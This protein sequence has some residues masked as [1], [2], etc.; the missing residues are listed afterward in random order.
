MTATRQCPCPAPE[1]APSGGCAGPESCGCGARERPFA[2]RQGTAGIALHDGR[3]LCFCV[4]REPGDLLLYVPNSR[5]KATCGD[6]GTRRPAP[7][8]APKGVVA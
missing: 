4:R 7:L 3:W 8:V 6:C 5:M 2:P 1:A